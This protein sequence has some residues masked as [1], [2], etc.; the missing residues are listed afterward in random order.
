M[1]MKMVLKQN[2]PLMLSVLMSQF[3]QPFYMN[4]GQ[5]MDKLQLD[6]LK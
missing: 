2:L 6:N 5:N 1:K 3:V 4:I